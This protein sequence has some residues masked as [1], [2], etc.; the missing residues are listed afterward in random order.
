MGERNP[1]SAYDVATPSSELKT[2]KEKKYENVSP[3]KFSLGGKIRTNRKYLE[4][5]ASIK[6]DLAKVG[7]LEKQIGTLSAENARVEQGSKSK[8]LLTGGAGL[9]DEQD[10]LSKRTLMGY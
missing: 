2:L 6:Q 1:T 9:E 5:Q 4:Q 10:T 3:V 8:T 7:E